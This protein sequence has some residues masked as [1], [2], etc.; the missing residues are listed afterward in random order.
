MTPNIRLKSQGKTVFAPLS[1]AAWTPATRTL[2]IPTT[3]TRYPGTRIKI[4]HI[5]IYIYICVC[6]VRY[7]LCRKRWDVQ[8]FHEFDTRP[9]ALLIRAFLRESIRAGEIWTCLDPEQGGP[10]GEWSS[11]HP[12]DVGVWSAHIV[13][14]LFMLFGYS[15]IPVKYKMFKNTFRFRWYAS[16]LET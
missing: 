15:V 10:C 12:W 9:F 14:Y 11:V 3:T 5:H 8:P 1:N 7:I 6:D 16:K 2:W 13:T 4:V